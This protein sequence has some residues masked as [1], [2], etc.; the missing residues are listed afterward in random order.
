MITAGPG[1]S[2]VGPP[3][4]PRKMQERNSI[5]LP[6]TPTKNILDYSD[7]AEEQ[8]PDYG[9]ILSRCLSPSPADSFPSP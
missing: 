9:I 1:A 8:A 6:P 7:L 2:L 5:I 3:R 4:S